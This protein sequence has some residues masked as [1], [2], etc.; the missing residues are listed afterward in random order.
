[1]AGPCILCNPFFDGKNKLV[2][3]FIKGNSTFLLFLVVFQTQTL[4]SAYIFA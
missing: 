2:K 1:M 4:A 3:A